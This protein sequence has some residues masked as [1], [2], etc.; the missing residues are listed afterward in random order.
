M[1]STSFR[2]WMIWMAG[3]VAFPIA[4]V[5]GTT[6]AGRADD[7][8][9]TLLGGTVT[10]AVLGAGQALASQGRLD[11]RTWVP[12]TAAG[13]GVGLTLG[14][15]TVDYGTALG[16]LALMGLVT[17]VVLGAAQTLALP[18]GTEHRWVWAAAMPVL[19]SLGWVVTTLIGYE[20]DKQV[21][22]F[23]ASGAFVF[24]ALAGVV[25]L[26]LLPTQPLRGSDAGSDPVEVRT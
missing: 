23:G 4:G 14:A 9:A 20:V 24:T 18:V 10:G 7:V 1:T 19:W 26:R 11:W 17:G 25:I 12:A 16:E 5:V 15:L 8:L 3:F 6:V 2:S 22:V 13:M 21:M